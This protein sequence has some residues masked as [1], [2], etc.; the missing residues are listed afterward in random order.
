M[1]L[2]EADFAHEDAF[3]VP[4]VVFCV[5]L[6]VFSL[7]SSLCMRCL[8]VCDLNVVVGVKVSIQQIFIPARLSGYLCT[9]DC[10]GPLVPKSKKQSEKNKSP[11]IQD[12]QPNITFVSLYFVFSHC[13][14]HRHRT[15]Q[16]RRKARE[17]SDKIRNKMV[18]PQLLRLAR[19]MRNSP[20]IV[21][22]EHPNRISVLVWVRLIAG[23]ARRRLTTG[24]A[25]TVLS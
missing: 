12:G 21:D 16:H 22:L 5:R 11:A 10:G 2:K 20:R 4:P 13:S 7:E 25:C 17:N 8:V 23:G 19:R 3:K 1:L 9:P 6:S 14:S 24:C 18:F 15:L